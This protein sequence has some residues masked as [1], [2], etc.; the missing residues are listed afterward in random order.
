ML[1]EP[2]AS[3]WKVVNYSSTEISFVFSFFMCHVS[4]VKGMESWSVTIWCKIV[5]WSFSSCVMCHV[6]CVM[7]QWYGKLISY[8][9]IKTLLFFFFFK[10]HVLCVM[11]HVSMTWKADQLQFDAKLF[12][13]FFLHVSCVMCHVSCVNDR[14]WHMTHDTWHFKKKKEKGNFYRTVI[15]QVSL[16]LIHDTWHMTHD[17][18]RKKR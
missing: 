10:C 4:C 3:L 5:F 8:N 7:C 2:D 6:S 18:S 12:F 14:G 17:T 11:C 16:S 13:P 1:R 9:L 15:D